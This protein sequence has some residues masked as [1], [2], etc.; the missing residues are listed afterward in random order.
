MLW[1][2]AVE[3]DGTHGDTLRIAAPGRAARHRQVRTWHPLS[4]AT[5]NRV[6]T[7]KR[8]VS[9]MC[10]LCPRGDTGAEEA[11]P[12]TDLHGPINE[13]AQLL[14]WPGSSRGHWLL[15]DA[16][17]LIDPVSAVDSGVSVII[18]ARNAHG[19]IDA[20]VKSVIA[21]FT[22]MFARPQWECIVVDDASPL[23]VQ[24]RS[25]EWRVSVLRNNQWPSVPAHGLGLRQARYD[26]VVFCD[27]D[28]L[29][30]ANFFTAH[31]PWQCVAPNM[32]TV[33]LD[34]QG[35][36]RAMACSAELA[37]QHLVPPSAPEDIETQA[38]SLGCFVRP[39]PQAQVISARA[40][41]PGRRP[42]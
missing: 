6:V 24:V 39:V 20:T 36:W 29:L 19:T 17:G 27:P 30:P 3:F 8:V 42:A 38:A 4:T 35:G 25:R 5:L 33:S 1:E 11:I 28:V 21:A 16:A 13:L 15:G 26:T 14:G 22:A 40:L 18:P 12:V 9:A 2:L 23:P 7:S 41:Q 10:M 34:E 37:A 31:L 32:I